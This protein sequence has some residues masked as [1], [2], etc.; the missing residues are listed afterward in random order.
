[1]KKEVI[2]VDVDEVLF[3]FT[4]RFLQHHNH[5]YGTKLDLD[6]F[7]SYEYHE[8]LGLPTADTVERVYEFHRLDHNHIEPLKEAREAIMALSDKYHIAAVTA[9]H[10]EFGDQTR[11]WLDL[12]FET[13]FHDVIAIGYE[14]AMDV[15]FTKAEICKQIN[16]VALIDDSLDHVAKCAA[17]G[18]QGILFGDYPWTARK[19][20]P[21]EVVRCRNWPEAL[22]YLNVS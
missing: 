18:V 2:A 10:P 1:M 13:K 19:N 6:D 3:P 7:I 4:D 12:H 20:I 21:T 11:A 5:T 9:R 22:R 8:V 17:Q 15:P 16:A 14:H